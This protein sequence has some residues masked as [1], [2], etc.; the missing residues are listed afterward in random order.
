MS[1][2]TPGRIY[3]WR[4]RGWNN[5][6]ASAYSSVDS[7]TIQYLPLATTLVYPTHNQADARADTLVFRVQKVDADSIYVF[8]TWTYVSGGQQFRS[9]TTKQNPTL[10][11]TGLSNRARYFWKVQ[12]GNQAGWS[13]F[14]AIDSF[15]TVV[16]LASTPNTV[17]P[18]NSSAEPRKTKFV[19]NKATNAVWY[20]LQVATTNF[21]SP[22]DIVEDA[23]IQTD[24]T[25][26]IKDT[27]KA[28]ILYYW[29]VSSVNLGGEGSFST[30]AHF[31]SGY[32]ITG[33]SQQIAEIP[34]DYS[35]LQ[36]Y[37]NPFNPSTTIS[38]DLPKTSVVKLYIYDVLGRVVANLVDGVQSANKYQIEWNPSR[39]SSG[40]YFCRIQAHSQDGSADF[41]SVKKLLYMK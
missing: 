26:T 21:A 9:D 10:T 38:Y 33:V 23:T 34:K 6:G 7:F 19:W 14:T 36:N 29:H 39:L 31:T 35:L 40:V 22:S 32:G 18:K 27:L 17:T 12:V 13:A 1:A 5:A 16:E 24:T 41:T 30:S 3:Y 20:H 25:Y 37:P 15:T 2:L 28:A 11:L 4:V 8:Q